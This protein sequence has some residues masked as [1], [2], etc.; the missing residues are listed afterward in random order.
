MT[1]HTIFLALGSNVGD[2]EGQMNDAI[3][4]LTSQVTHI[5][6]APFYRSKP[7]GVTNQPDFVNMALKGSTILSPG[8]LLTFVKAIEQQIG[9]VYRY[10]WGP[11]EIDI[12]IIFYDNLIFK[13]ETL[14]IP[15]PRA[16]ERDFV[17]RPISDLDPTFVHPVFHKQVDELLTSLLPED[18]VI[19][20]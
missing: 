5:S 12:D 11:R 10:R 6:R 16:V 18:K 3:K 4:L 7:M 1:D 17:L 2:Q 8:E 19:L 13:S 15:H 14:E 9:R 20:E